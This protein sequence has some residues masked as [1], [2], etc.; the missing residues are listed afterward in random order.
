MAKLAPLRAEGLELAIFPSGEFGNQELGSDAEI[1]E[2]AKGKGFEGIIF[3]KGPCNSRP[4]FQTLQALSGGPEIGWNFKGLY[5]VSKTGEVSEVKD[6]MDVE[7]LVK[8]NL[9]E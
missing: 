5:V 1:V 3:T 2:F 4:V 6:G 7:E 8:A 9:A